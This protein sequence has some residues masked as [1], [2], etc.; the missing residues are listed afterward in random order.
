MVVDVRAGTD[1]SREPLNPPPALL[2]PLVGGQSD[3]ES[4]WPSVNA[5]P[6]GDRGDLE[7]TIIVK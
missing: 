6:G 7:E 1:R 3:E 5:R 2:P 4:I